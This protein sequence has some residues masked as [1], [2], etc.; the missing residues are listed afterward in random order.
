MV[1]QP[2]EEQGNSDHAEQPADVRVSFGSTPSES[3]GAPEILEEEKDGPH[4]RPLLQAAFKG[5]WESAKRF[6]ERDPPSKTAKIT[7]RSETVLHIAALSAQDQFWRTWLS[8]CL[9]MGKC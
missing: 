6:F 9:H 5:D 1:T 2:S 8:C 4:Y 3:G 7:G